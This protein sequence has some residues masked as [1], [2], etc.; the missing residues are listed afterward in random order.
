[1]IK[2]S[3]VRTISN[4]RVVAVAVVAGQAHRLDTFIQ[5]HI[6]RQLLSPPQGMPF[7]L[8][9]RRSSPGNAVDAWKALWFDASI[10]S[11]GFAHGG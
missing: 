7:W 9:L 5:R 10:C 1:M 2:P 4:I 6:Q 11:Q 3:G 8:M